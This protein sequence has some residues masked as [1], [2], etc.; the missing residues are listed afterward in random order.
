MPTGATPRVVQSARTT[1]DVWRCSFAFLVL[2][3][4]VNG[5]AFAADADVIDF[6]RTG[7]I[8]VLD[9]QRQF[10]AGNVFFNLLGQGLFGLIGYDRVNPVWVFWGVSTL[11]TASA[12]ALAVFM[13]LAKYGPAQAAIFL[14][15]LALTTLDYTL[16]HWVGKTDAFVVTIYLA[17]FLN[18]TSLV[19]TA[20][21]FIAMG[22]FHLE[23]S[24]FLAAFHGVVLWFERKLTPALVGAIALAIGAAVAIRL[25]YDHVNG[26]QSARNRWV[27]LVTWPVPMGG[28]GFYWFLTNWAA[29]TVTALFGAWWLALREAAESKR[30]FWIIA[31]L[32]AGAVLGGALTLDYSRVATIL[33]FPLA[34]LLAERTAAAHKDGVALPWPQAT[35]LLAIAAF[36]FE[37][38]GGA[39]RGFLFRD[40]LG[41]ISRL[42]GS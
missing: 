23:Q 7:S 37:I 42:T 2:C 21:G 16:L 22:G 4:V 34:C 20:I 19:A 38:V 15:C 10:L 36:G 11:I 3:V 27:G 30:T 35:V 40:L 5:A 29:C 26:F 9:P 31:A 33:A 32:A 24:I 18:R 28:L 13:S 6:W 12:F 39:M 41:A 17:T 25:G 14:G 1:G 8:E